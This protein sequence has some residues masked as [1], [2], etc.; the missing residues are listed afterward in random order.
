MVNICRLF[1]RLACVI[2]YCNANAF[3]LFTLN[4]RLIPLAVKKRLLMLSTP[5]KKSSF[6]YL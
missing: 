4:A 5:Q 6:M 3:P 1:L 2:Y